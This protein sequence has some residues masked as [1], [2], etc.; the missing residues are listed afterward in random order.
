MSQTVL[1]HDACLRELKCNVFFYARA[2]A[3]AIWAITFVCDR[4]QPVQQPDRRRR[5]GQAVRRPGNQHHASEAVVSRGMNMPASSLSVCVVVLMEC[6]RTSKL[7]KNLY[8]YL[9]A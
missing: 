9:T 5:G 2:S 8:F 1:A 7:S 6:V 3:V 4:L